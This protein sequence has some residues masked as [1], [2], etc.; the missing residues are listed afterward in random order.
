MFKNLVL[1]L[2]IFCLHL[3][4]YGNNNED[5]YLISND[6]TLLQ[7]EDSVEF[8]PE[9]KP[10]SKGKFILSYSSDTTVIKLK[11]KKVPSGEKNVAYPVGY[12]AAIITSRIDVPKSDGSYD[13]RNSFRIVVNKLG[14]IDT[15]KLATGHIIKNEKNYQ[16]V[17]N[18][19]LESIVMKLHAKIQHK[20]SANVH[21]KWESIPENA[22][23]ILAGNEDSAT[24]FL[25][26]AGNNTVI[27][28]AT[29]QKEKDTIAYFD[30]TRIGFD[31]SKA[32]VQKIG[33]ID[34]L[35]HAVD[36]SGYFLYDLD[37]N[38]KSEFT[39]FV[40]LRDG[41]KYKVRELADGRIW[42]QEYLRYLAIDKTSYTKGNQYEEKNGI[43]Y[44]KYSI[45]TGKPASELLY[46]GR[47]QSN[48]RIQGIC[49]KGWSIPTVD[50][51][52]NLIQITFRNKQ[53]SP[54]IDLN[55]TSS[56]EIDNKKLGLLSSLFKA[57]ERPSATIENTSTSFNTSDLSGLSLG[58]IGTHYDATSAANGTSFAL[59]SMKDATEFYSFV[60]D[61]KASPFTLIKPK[62]A[63]TS[64]NTKKVEAIRCIKDKD[65]K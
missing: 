37:I 31:Y 57:G 23:Q 48:K 2:G 53:L 18:G 33:G 62:S 9:V 42:M 46:N 27:L 38:R 29:Y 58:L 4:T 16:V 43:Y 50:D 61:L 10:I 55:R 59:A 30:Y 35:I 51:I 14:E 8:T 49:P 22:I 26:Y 5:F 34:T 11:H 13:K 60:I 12:G 20:Y 47:A 52:Y 56:F 36:S 1:A 6:T 64:S 45:A 28:T 65:K 24:I 21:L 39:H 54:D 40:D 15:T 63:S 41:N 44:Y 17:D 32:Q 25:R 19:K 3:S 7:A